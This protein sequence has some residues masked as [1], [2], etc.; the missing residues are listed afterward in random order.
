MSHDE[1]I[2]VR[3]ATPADAKDFA[4]LVL[5]SSPCLCPAIYGDDVKAIMCYLFSQRRNLFGFEHAYFVEVNGQI[6]GMLLG[7]DWR[8]RS[9]EN[10]RTGFLLL[11]QMKGSFLVR[12][13]QMVK[14]EGAIGMVR[15]WKYHISNIAVHPEYMGKGLGSSLILEAEK[16]ARSNDAKVVSLEVEVENAGAI[17]FYHRLGYSLIR[18]SS[19]Q[20]RGGKHFHFHRMRKNLS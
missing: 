9:R 6:A 2:V 12:F 19:I 13:P 15:E 4:D 5:F 18:E 3:K 7:Y 11:R 20:L 1:H 16:E 10:W 8:A 17:K 14:A